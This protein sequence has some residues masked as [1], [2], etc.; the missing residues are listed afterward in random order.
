MKRLL[1]LLLL[2]CVSIPTLAQDAA[3]PDLSQNAA[4]RYWMA[5]ELL[6]ENH[7]GYDQK[8]WNPEEVI[9]EWDTV[10]LEAHRREIEYYTRDSA[11]EILHWAAELDSCLW[12]INREAG[13]YTLLPHLHPMRRA[14]RLAMLSAR[15]RLHDGDAFGAVEDI[16]LVMKLSHAADGD[17]IL[18]SQLVG[19]SIESM[20]VEWVAAN[21]SAFDDA[22][23]ALLAEKMEALPARPALSELIQGERDVFLRW[24]EV[25]LQAAADGELD[26]EMLEFLAN[27]LGIDHPVVR[28]I[29]RDIEQWLAWTED[30]NAAYDA[31]GRVADLPYAD[32][33]EAIGQLEVGFDQTDNQVIALFMPSIVTVRSSHDKALA[34]R[35]MLRAMLAVRL[36]GEDTDLADYPTMQDPFGDGTFEPI[37][38]RRDD[39]M[40][41]GLR[42][43]LIGRDGERVE[44]LT[45][46]PL[47]GE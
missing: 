35:A 43:A 34:R 39:G 6:P 3:E 19:L 7:A 14:S 15:L 47:A 29:E 20:A 36:D 28:Q 5:F 10:D 21:L 2:V 38:E 37:A 8:G 40:V 44:L 18:I 17:L 4:L 23:I 12:S 45:D 9:G 22:S 32:Y 1:C 46:A 42:S 26:A 13:P 25:R 31:A 30:A 27:G 16:A 11:L 33:L 24:W 41:Y